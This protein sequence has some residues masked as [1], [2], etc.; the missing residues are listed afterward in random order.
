[1]YHSTNCIYL[2]TYSLG[3]TQCVDSVSHSM[4]WQVGTW[5]QIHTHTHI[6]NV[7]T[8]YSQS[9]AHGSCYK[10]AILH[11]DEVCVSAMDR[12]SFCIF[13][14]INYMH[15]QPICTKCAFAFLIIY[16]AIIFCPHGS[17]QSSTLMSLQMVNLK[18]FAELYQLVWICRAN[19][20]PTYIRF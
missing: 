12:C 17:I 6:P 9:A 5:Q 10:P 1:M 11:I 14:L 7:P 8:L 19:I 3:S 13:C 15:F 20:S 4:L 2:Y 16:V 18:I